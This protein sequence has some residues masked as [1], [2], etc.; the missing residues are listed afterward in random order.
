MTAAKYNKSKERTVSPLMP[1][2]AVFLLFLLLFLGNKIKEGVICGIE[3]CLYT[4]IP[5]LFPFF[6]LSDFLLSVIWIN[7]NGPV[8]KIY[9]GAFGISS[10]TLPVFLIGSVCGFPLGIRNA[11]AL[12]KDNKITKRELEY[13]CG[14]VNN[15]SVA[16]VIS[17]VGAGLLGDAKA[18]V[19]LYIS[20]VI[21]AVIVG[22]IFRS[23]ISVSQKNDIISRQSFNLVESIRS[24]GISSL[25][26]SSYIIFFS[27]LIGLLSEIVKSEYLMAAISSLLEISNGAKGIASLRSISSIPKLC[28]I[29]FSLGFSGLSVH[30]QSFT[31][32]P[33]EVSKK[34]YLLMKLVQGLLCALIVFLF[35]EIKKAVC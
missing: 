26:V 32:M 27:S 13:I 29:A 16:F 9:R 24:A 30:L 8:A 20:T 21:S 11:S 5:T 22:L 15:P 28:G 18:G 33:K 19:L 4:I 14:F 3:L 1:Y 25:I 23:K 12:Y 35:S 6:V 10:V 7:P 17:G 34:K 2:A 31:F